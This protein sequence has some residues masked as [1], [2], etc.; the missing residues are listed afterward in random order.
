MT[1]KNKY[2]K[3]FREAGFNC[4]PLKRR[5]AADTKVADHTWKARRTEQNLPIGDRE[6]YGVCGTVGHGNGILDLDD[7]EK[8]RWFADKIISKG[9][10]VI[11]TGKGWHVPVMGFSDDTSKLEFV[12]AQTGGDKVVE[13][14][15][16]DHYVVGAGSIIWHDKLDREVVYENVGSDVI[17]NVKGKDFNAWADVI[18]RELKLKPKKKQSNSS[19]K[20]LRDKFKERKIPEKGQSNDYFH[21]AALVCLTDGLT[22]SE[23]EETIKEIYDE[24]SKSD[25][26]SNR[27]WT[28]VRSKIEYTY[29]H[30]KPLKAGR[31]QG[32]GG[33]IDRTLIAQGLI[34]SRKLY[35]NVDTGNIFENQN[36]FLEL[37]NNRIGRE[38]II[39]FP[40]LEEADEKAIIY[41]LVRMAEPMPETNDDYFVFK[42]GV[43]SLSTREP[44]ET[45]E[46]GSMGFKD[47]DYLP[48]TKEN[49]PK[50]FLRV[51]F[52]NIPKHE[53]PRAKAGLKSILY[54]VHD[55]RITVLIGGAGSG[56]TKATEILD[57]VLGDEYS[58][59]V[60]ISQFVDDHFI[61]AHIDGKRLLI[62]QDMP[63]SFKDFE[64]IKTTTGESSKTERGF[65]QDKIK[66]VNRLKIFGCANYL[67]KIPNSEKEPM[68]NRRLSLLHKEPPAVPYK[69][70][71]DLSRRIADEEGEKIISWIFNLTDEECQY[72]SG[73]VVR[74]EWESKASPEIEYLTN[75][76][77]YLED[78]IDSYGVIRLVK[79]FNELYQ[80][81]ITIDVMADALKEEGYSVRNN[82]VK[83]IRKLPA[84]PVQD[85]TQKKF[86][87]DDD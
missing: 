71:P 79:E 66:V 24:W 13:F 29:E 45:D 75:H 8:Y 28:S 77:E 51:F 76:F 58:Y 17:W 9:F 27:P 21:Q 64:I 16:V 23:A 81:D 85:D 22:L 32:G 70:D 61:R 12:D 41:K 34:E 5:G 52:G 26:Y 80:M 11:E 40:Q 39:P 84:K 2:I 3:I 19:Y 59:S 25:H 44:V 10:M 33:D 4:F 68:Y 87:S 7:K 83:N 43:R 50:E 74:K 65:H 18:S 31:P 15:G 6:N 73:K 42:N 57:Y 35:S 49:E 46:I 38:L 47:Y 1:D 86:R 48:P 36:G 63:D 54:S 53:W 55:P 72:E 20:H 60:T 56:K 78:S 67:A 69:E 14:Q 62:F 37:Y 30:D 82:I